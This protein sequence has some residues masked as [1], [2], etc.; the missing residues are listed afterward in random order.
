[1]RFEVCN[2]DDCVFCRIVNGIEPASVVYSDNEVLAF[3]DI[4]PVNPGHLLVIPKA[5]VAQLSDLDLGK[6]AHSDFPQHKI[7]DFLSEFLQVVSWII[8]P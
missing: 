1:M 8:R 3:M 4:T 2:L 6:G 5:H 7:N